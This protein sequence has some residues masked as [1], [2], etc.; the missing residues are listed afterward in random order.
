MTAS[1]HVFKKDLSDL[2]KQQIGIFLKVVR[3]AECE[4]LVNRLRASGCEPG[5]PYPSHVRVVAG[6]MAGLIIS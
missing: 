5:L 3:G 1:S 4:L 6:G 2:E